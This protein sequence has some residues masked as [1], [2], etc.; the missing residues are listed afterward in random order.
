[1]S[2]TSSEGLKR[3]REEHQLAVQQYCDDPR[4]HRYPRIDAWSFA[5]SGN[6]SYGA[7]HDGRADAEGT[8]TDSCVH[9]SS[10]I[11][12]NCGS[13]ITTNTDRHL[14]PYA[15]SAHPVS[16]SLAL[17][18]A[19]SSSLPPPSCR[20]AR[21]ACGDS[22]M[23]LTLRSICIW[24]VRGDSSRRCSFLVQPTFVYT[25]HCS[26][27]SCESA[28]EEQAGLEVQETVRCRVS[29]STATRGNSANVMRTTAMNRTAP[30]AV[31]SP[32]APGPAT[33]SGLFGGSSSP[34]CH[35]EE[36]SNPAVTSNISDDIFADGYSYEATQISRCRSIPTCLSGLEECASRLGSCTP[37]LFVDCLIKCA[38]D[39]AAV[40]LD[41][42]HGWVHLYRGRHIATEAGRT[43]LLRDVFALGDFGTVSAN[44]I[45][46]CDELPS[47][48]ICVFRKC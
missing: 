25:W 7:S 2:S 30:F 12:V 37:A 13:S 4:R 15:A 27:T 29:S 19:Q 3:R 45:S 40:A 23:T 42:R 9:V 34:L 48:T 31:G 17:S 21:R 47:L 18:S 16:A 26:S 24:V 8:Q 20:S 46:S 44:S 43:R 41:D 22:E 28:G 33:M 6:P 32:T 39:E 14:C 1:M 5:I 36:A 35:N 38:Q 11:R 10:S